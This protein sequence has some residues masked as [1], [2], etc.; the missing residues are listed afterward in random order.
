M[1]FVIPNA[2]AQPLNMARDFSLFLS[3]CLSL[4]VPLVT[5]CASKQR[6]LWRDSENA[7]GLLN[8]RCSPVR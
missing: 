3:L 4:K 7:K 2:S 6:M 5:Y 8:F 1:R